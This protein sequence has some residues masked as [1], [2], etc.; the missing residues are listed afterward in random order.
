MKLPLAGALI[1]ASAQAS[2]HDWYL[3][4][5]VPNSVSR[6]CCGDSDCREREIR[7]NGE[8]MEIEILINDR[9]WLA[10]DARWFKGPSPDSQ[11][12]GCMLAADREPRC[13]WVGE[14]T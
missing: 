8:T 6:F 13:V 1:L 11:A 14:G 2:A 7:F 10:T 12:H 9:W 4:E 5:M 3:Y